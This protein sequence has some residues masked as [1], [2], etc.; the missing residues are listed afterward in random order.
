M[1]DAFEGLSEEEGVRGWE[2]GAVVE[3]VAESQGAEEVEVA[4]EEDR[5][6]T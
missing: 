1:R 4:R 2:E 3:R 6:K 5:L